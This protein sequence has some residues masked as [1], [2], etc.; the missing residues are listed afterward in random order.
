MQQRWRLLAQQLH[1]LLLQLDSLH[2]AALWRVIYL[3]LWRDWRIDGRYG[4]MG[5]RADS[6][7]G[8]QKGR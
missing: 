3:P 7:E 2:S 6:Y 5:G 4:W 8:R 1:E